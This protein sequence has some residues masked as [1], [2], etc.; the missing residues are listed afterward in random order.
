MA[1]GVARRTPSRALCAGELPPSWDL[2][3]SASL[4]PLNNFIVIAQV[5][6]DAAIACDHFSGAI[7]LSSK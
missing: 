5:T 2:G 6:V 3:A 7:S 1:K 4:N